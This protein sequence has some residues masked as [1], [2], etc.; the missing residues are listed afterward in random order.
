MNRIQPTPLTV[1]DAPLDLGRTY[2]LVD[3]QNL[4]AGNIT[5]ATLASVW[6]AY[7]STI[8]VHDDDALVVACGPVAAP[9]VAFNLPA[10]ARLLIGGR[11]PDAGTF[12]LLNDIDVDFIRRRYDSVVLGS[13]D[14]I[15]T[16]AAI[17]L[18]RRG[19]RVFGV[20]RSDRGYSRAL[21]MAT[22]RVFW[23][24]PHD[25]LAA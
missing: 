24:R 5:Q 7:G 21:R 4:A 9:T 17:A 3:A 11:G 6:K 20:G 12:A 19:V 15:F 14:G 25:Q 2:H 23:I 1:S 18:A 16:S 13:A 8:R 22:S 10:R